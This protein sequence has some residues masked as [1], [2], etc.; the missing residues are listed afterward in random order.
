MKVDSNGIQLEVETFGE[1]TNPALVL[2]MG[3]GCQMT[4]WP[5]AFCQ[6]LAEAGFYVVRFDNRDVGLSSRL[7]HLG[8]PRLMREILRQRLGLRPRAP[9][10]LH[11]LVKDTV[12][13][14][15]ALGIRRAHIVG[16]SMGGMVAQLMAL[17]YPE[18]LA[19]LT[20]MM[21]TSGNPRLPQPSLSMQLRLIRRPKGRDRQALIE[22]GI[23]TWQLMA[24]PHNPPSR[25]SLE[26][27]VAGLVD[28]AITPRGYIRQLLAV[29]ASGARHRKL[30]D[31]T[32]PTLVVH[33][34][35]DPLI[36][37]AAGEELA[38]LIHG[39]RLELVP[40]MGHDLPADIFPG[41]AM[42]IAAHAGSHR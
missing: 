35:D 38:R 22:H 5:L 1:N 23:R 42:K 7:D 41:I 31:I 9:Y 13:L 28:R 32:L 29:M 25:E 26:P 36:P 40:R 39:A 10:R 27:F 15:D 6:Q 14:L 12:G 17:Q 20:L 21:T 18:R 30:A 33:G 11:A 34:V 24:S 3:L 16:L 8:T 4:V 2:I 19:S 37:K